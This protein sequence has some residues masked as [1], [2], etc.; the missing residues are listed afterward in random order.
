VSDWPNFDGI[1][2]QQRLASEGVTETYVAVQEDLGRKVVVKAL[3]P[4]VLPSSPFA[5]ALKREAQIL[6]ELCHPHVQRLYDFRCTDS[7]MWLVLEHLDGALLSEIL[8][9]VGPLPPLAVA[10]LGFMVASGLAHCHARGTIHRAI[11][12]RC[13]TLARSGAATLVGFVGAVKDRLPTA[14]E[15]LDGS[16]HLAVSPYFSPE[17]VLGESVDARS[18]IFSLGVLLY[19]ALTGKNPFAGPDDRSVAQR[20]RK[21]KVPPVS[22]FVRSVPSALERTLHRCLEK[23][24]QDRFSSA[25]ELVAAFESLLREHDVVSVQGELE[26]A[27]LPYFDAKTPSRSAPTPLASGASNARR[28]MSP[29]AAGLLGLLLGSTLIAS[30]GYLFQLRQAPEATPARRNAGRL[31]LAPENAASLRIVASPW[32]TVTI[33]GQEIGTTP[34]GRA[35]ALAA[36][37]H[38]VQLEH[39]RASVERRVI[40]LAAGETVLLDVKMNVAPSASSAAV[41]SNSPDA[42]ASP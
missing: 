39:P 28:E 41:P 30:G 20:I 15:L 2:I 22:R 19:E 4:S 37:T 5:A 10:G 12:P 38:Y 29:L 9:K 26:K 3:S 11:E 16:P 21:D 18:D 13:V 25:K 32:A 23:M 8:A 1:R 7:Q 24:P 31:E 6:G 36:G 33:D 35:I 40:H 42:S 34:I 17:Q 14:P 27:L